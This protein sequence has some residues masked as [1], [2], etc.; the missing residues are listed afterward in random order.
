MTLKQQT[1]NIQI[2]K[3]AFHDPPY[4][5]VHPGQDKSGLALDSN[6]SVTKMATDK[7]LT[8]T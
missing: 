4:C 8:P 5:T 2:Q 6:N 7:R 1:G 3:K